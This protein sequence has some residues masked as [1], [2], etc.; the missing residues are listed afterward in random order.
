MLKGIRVLE[1]SSANTML[2]GSILA[3]LGADVVVVEPPGGATGR[4]LEPFL[5][6]KPGL[7]RSLTWQALNRNKR[8]ITLNL[9]VIDGRE[10]LESITSKFDVLLESTPTGASPTVGEQ[11]RL[12]PEM[13]HCVLHPFFAGGPKAQY[14]QSDLVMM[15][16]SGSLGM[17]GE[18]DRPPLQFPFPQAMMEAGAEAA[19]A[20]LAALNARDKDGVGQTCP[21]GVVAA[22]RRGCGARP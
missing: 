22:F 2:A 18:P 6:N 4:R 16:A 5:D 9:D 14:L 10:L 20:V 21:G 13:I 17:S 8:G 7:E 1:V 19:I 11:I 12:R 15:A 3:D